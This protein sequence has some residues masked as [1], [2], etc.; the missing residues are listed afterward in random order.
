MDALMLLGTELHFPSGFYH[1]IQMRYTNGFTESLLLAPG[2][3]FVLPFDGEL[4]NAVAM[5][6]NEGT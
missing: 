2:E 1:E 4:V 5:L 6:T 3:T